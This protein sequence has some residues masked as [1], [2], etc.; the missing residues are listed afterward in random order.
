MLL[1]RGP[2][3]VYLEGPSGGLFALWHRPRSV[4]TSTS[5][6]TVVY[7]PPFAEEMNRS[8]RTIALLGAAMAERGIGL[9]ILDL[10]GT[11]DSAGEFAEATWSGWLGDTQAALRFI[12]SEGHTITGIMGLRT[13]ALLALA[14]AR[15]RHLER[16]ML[17]QPVETGRSYLT[18]LLR[19]RIA[20]SLTGVGP[21][22]T[23]EA[24]RAQLAGGQSVEIMGYTLS[25]KLWAEL[26]E[27]DLPQA[28]AGFAGRIDWLHLTTS[29]TQN[30]PSKTT[31][32]IS[33]LGEISSGPVC[34]R[35]VATPAFWLLEAPP[36]DNFVAEAVRL[37]ADETTVGTA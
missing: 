31:E 25:P 35:I 32:E 16:V 6:K 13:G 3:P 8:R 36:A 29:P 22:L 30:L 15:A 37:W 34:S 12:E 10:F 11:G 26:E 2:L 23:T 27:L 14:A 17:C 9:F 18:G 5:P 19:S 33:R 28:G 21:R 20:A 24:L 4:A 1:R 7:V